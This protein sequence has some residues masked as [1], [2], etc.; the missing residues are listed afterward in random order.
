MFG[1]SACIVV[2][3]PPMPRASGRR[4][5]ME[6]TTTLG[7]GT[8]VGRGVGM[9]VGVSVLAPPPHPNP[10]HNATASG[11]ARA[12]LRPSTKPP[13]PWEAPR[14]ATGRFIGVNPCLG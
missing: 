9:G 2:V 13:A 4:P 8:G 11:R 1:V 14:P 12:Q 10:A 6:I 5:S 3:V 7:D